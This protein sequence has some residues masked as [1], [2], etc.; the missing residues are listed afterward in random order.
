MSQQ[1]TVHI[2]VVF[3]AT[4]A[5]REHVQ[6]GFESNSHKSNYILVYI[7]FSALINLKRGFSS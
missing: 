5:K 1:N 4:E 7:Q 3:G 2:K 6:V